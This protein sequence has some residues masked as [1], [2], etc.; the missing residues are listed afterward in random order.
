MLHLRLKKQQK[1]VFS[2]TI[3]IV[4]KSKVRIVQ[5]TRLALTSAHEFS[6]GVAVQIRHS[7]VVFSSVRPNQLICFICDGESVRPAKAF[8]NYHTSYA[9]IHPRLPYVRP[10]S[11]VCPVKVSAK[12]KTSQ[13]NSAFVNA[14]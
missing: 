13:L 9:A 12:T 2:C 1:N 3:L 8:A 10:V 4:P 14:P 5:T 6:D 7:D 11:P